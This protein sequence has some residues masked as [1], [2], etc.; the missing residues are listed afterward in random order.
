MNET[1]A[2]NS[3]G[4]MQVDTSKTIAV[5]TVDDEI[6]CLA[7]YIKVSELSTLHKRIAFWLDEFDERGLPFPSALDG[8]GTYGAILQA[9]WQTLLAL[10]AAARADGFHVLV[11]TW[12]R[13]HHDI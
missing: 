8:R 5:V 2:I 6:R 4:N 13:I 11:L 10:I 9:R 12:D 3:L 1:K 7:G